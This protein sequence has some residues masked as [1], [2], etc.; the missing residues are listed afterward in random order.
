MMTVNKGISI[1]ISVFKQNS[2]VNL[3]L[4]QIVNSNTSYTGD[5]EIIVIGDGYKVKLAAI[6]LNRFG[7]INYK[8]KFI[9]KF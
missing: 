1:I 4:N 2:E 9:M 3:L 6:N 7:F 5:Y 8:T